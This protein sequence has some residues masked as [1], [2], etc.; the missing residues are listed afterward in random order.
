MHNTGDWVTIEEASRL[1]GV[2]R[3]TVR[4]R[5]KAGRY[6]AHKV[7][8]P[9]GE[10]VMIERES[11]GLVPHTGAAEPPTTTVRHK[12]HNPSQNAQDPRTIAVEALVQSLLAPFIAELGTVREELGRER[13]RREQAERERDELK[14]RLER[15]EPQQQHSSIPRI[16]ELEREVSRLESERNELEAQLKALR[17]PKCD[18]QAPDEPQ[19]M[20]R[21][22]RIPEPVKQ[23][24][25]QFWQR[26]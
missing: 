11:L 16:R 20:A 4:N 10:T 25:W 15:K 22:Y 18:D 2:H 13:E 7:V 1:L 23:R 9:Q 6:K 8:T 12:A 19:V 17:L 5:V 21:E 14:A 3:N 24:R 26:S